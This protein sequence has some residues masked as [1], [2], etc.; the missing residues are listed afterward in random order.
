DAFVAIAKKKINDPVGD[1]RLGILPTLAPYLLPLFIRSLSSKY[2]GLNVEIL[3]LNAKEMSKGFENNTLDGAIA[4]SPFIKEGFYESPLFK[5]DFVL[6]IHP[7]HDLAAREQVNWSDAPLNE[8]LLHEALKRYLLSSVEIKDSAGL[9]SKNLNN[10]NYQSGSLETMRKIIDKNG[11]LT[12]LP[13]LAE[14]YMGERRKKMIRPIV[15]PVLSR[16]IT[17][18]T[19]RGFE[20]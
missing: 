5:E 1:F 2:P 6:Y 14:L 15:D 17:F 18:V 13:Q 3:E 11:G 20:K 19:P 4:I 12:I 7:D 8:L 16:M 9:T 10:I